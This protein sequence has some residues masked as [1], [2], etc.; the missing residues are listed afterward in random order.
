MFSLFQVED[1]S[2]F[3][4]KSQKATELHLPFPFN[5]EI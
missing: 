3:C 1:E 2:I 4:G 5:T